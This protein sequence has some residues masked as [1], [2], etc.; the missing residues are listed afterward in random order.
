MGDHWERIEL[1]EEEISMLWREN[2][3]LHQKL[4]Q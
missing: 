3:D 4:E 1:L 2:M